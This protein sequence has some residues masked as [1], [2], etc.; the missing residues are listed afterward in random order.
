MGAH[1]RGSNKAPSA[2]V[3]PTAEAS[4]AT[5]SVGC[6]PASFD[7]DNEEHPVTGKN[8]GQVISETRIPTEQPGASK[9]VCEAETAQQRSRAESLDFKASACELTPDAPQGKEVD[10]R[11][12]RECITCLDRIARHI[13]G[14]G[15]SRRW[16]CQTGH[17]I[18]RT[19]ALIQP[20]QM[21]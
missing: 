15:F 2:L 19:Q 5:P 18:N 1:L 4:K 11:A 14:A 8:W 3:D 21:K 12:D 20:T 7:R 13:A 10:M 9:K 16:S 17:P 6:G